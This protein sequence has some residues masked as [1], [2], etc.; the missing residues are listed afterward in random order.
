MY[1]DIITLFNRV[2]GADG[3]TWRATVLTGVN[4]VLD[5]AALID[6]YGESTADNAMLNVRLYNT[7]GTKWIVSNDVS[8]AYVPPK[9]YARLADKTGYLTFTPGNAFDFYWRGIWEG[10]SVISDD[11]YG[12]MSFYDWMTQNYDHVYAV[13]SFSELSVIPHLEIAGR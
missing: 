7:G 12:D 6:T 1:N 2:R 10:S 4:L 13:S 8:F 9:E 3:D 5:K 11:N